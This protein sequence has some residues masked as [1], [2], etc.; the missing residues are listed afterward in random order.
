MKKWFVA[1]V[2]IAFCLPLAANA[3]DF[4]GQLYGVTTDGT[5]FIS[6]KLVDKAEGDAPKA[7]FGPSWNRKDMQ[8]AGDYFIFKSGVKKR[9]GVKTDYCF[10][11]GGDRY[12]PHALAEDPIIKDGDFVDNGKGG[13]N[14]RTGP[15]D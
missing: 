5:Y 9:L 12:I 11:I 1:L 2:V 8:A 10:D 6:K 7:M 3:Q 13:Y 14:F 4:K 15:I